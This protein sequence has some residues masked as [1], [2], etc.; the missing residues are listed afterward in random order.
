LGLWPEGFAVDDLPR[1]PGSRR[2]LGAVLAA[3]VDAGLLEFEQLPGGEH[4][5][6]AVADQAPGQ[7]TL[8]VS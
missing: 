1:R 6:A 7:I 3:M 5:R 2:Q 8:P 4:Y